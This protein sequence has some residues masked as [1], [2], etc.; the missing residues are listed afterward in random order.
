MAEALEQVYD[1][2]LLD[3][4]RSA[5]N[6]GL[7]DD[8]PARVEIANPLCGDVL[9]L[10]AWLDADRL[11][12]LRFSCECCGI[13]MGN[14]S[15]MTVTVVGMERARLRQVAG[16]A[17]AVLAGRAGSG[18]G[19]EPARQGETWALL[20]AIATSLPARRTCASLG[21]QALLALLD[22]QA[23]SSA[24]EIRG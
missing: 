4:I 16:H 21:W 5:R 10:Q 24:R 19:A 17:L 1:S 14:T 6:Y 18:A 13:A 23:S 9:Q 7:V 3:H 8:G 20:A 2:L 22:G 11:T 15:L 12:A